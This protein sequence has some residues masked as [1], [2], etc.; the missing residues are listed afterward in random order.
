MNK[1]LLNYLGHINYIIL[2][3]ISIL[4][5]FVTI[6]PDNYS[7]IYTPEFGLMNTPEPA[8]FDAT[9]N[10]TGPDCG[11]IRQGAVVDHVIT[12]AVRDSCN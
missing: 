5:A 3:A 2:Q 10:P 8:L 6:N 4:Q 9:R 11:E 1:G 12:R 7:P